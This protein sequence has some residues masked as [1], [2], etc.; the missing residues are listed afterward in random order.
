M[1]VT[2]SPYVVRSGSLGTIPPGGCP[3]GTH[4]T[5]MLPAP[6]AAP[7]SAP[8]ICTKNPTVVTQTATVVNH[9][10]G[11]YVGIALAAVIVFKV[12]TR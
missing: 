12:A 3:A 9:N 1:Q 7:G 11:L 8:C 6:G 5:C 4:Q 2:R 10:W